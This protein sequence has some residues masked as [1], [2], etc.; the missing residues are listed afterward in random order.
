MAHDNSDD[1]NDNKSHRSLFIEYA[2]PGIKKR[3]ST[4]LAWLGLTIG[5]FG[6]PVLY[7]GYVILF[8]PNFLGMFSNVDRNTPSFRKQSN[9]AIAGIPFLGSLFLW[10]LVLYT[11][12]PGRWIALAGVIFAIPCFAW[13]L[14]IALTVGFRRMPPG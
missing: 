11:N 9:F 2:A 1:S 4:G 3:G 8:D 13:V 7:I 10:L 14:N 6:W 12:R 5:L